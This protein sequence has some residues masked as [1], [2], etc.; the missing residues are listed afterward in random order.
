M[1]EITNALS[2]KNSSFCSKSRGFKFDTV[3]PYHP[4]AYDRKVVVKTAIVEILKNTTPGDRTQDVIGTY[5]D[6]R[7]DECGYTNAQ[8]RQMNFLFDLRRIM[9]YVTWETRTPEFVEGGQVT[10][11]SSSGDTKQLRVSPDLI[12]RGSD[13][14]GKPTAELVYIDPGKAYLTNKG[15][16][17]KAQRE[18]MMYATMLYARQLGFSGAT[19]SIYFMKK[20][21]D[22]N[23]QLDPDFY[24]RNVV[25]MKDLGDRTDDD[26]SDSV[27][28][29][30]NGED[31]SKMKEE[32][33]EHCKYHSICQYTLPPIKLIEENHSSNKMS[34][35]KPTDAQTQAMNAV[36]GIFRLNAGAGSGK[37]ATVTARTKHLIM[38]L[39]VRPE[40]ILMITFTDAGAKE[41]KA[42]IGALLEDAG[43]K[44]DIEA[45]NVVTFNSFGDTIVKEQYK[46][47]FAKPPIVINDVQR[48]A[49]IEKLLTAQPIPEW[50]G[51]P[52][53]N[54][55][56][57]LT[58]APGALL[59]AS[60]VFAAIRKLNI[61]AATVQDIHS[62]MESYQL[63]ETPDSVISKLIQL[64]DAYD[65]KLKANGLIEFI[66]QE[67]LMFEVLDSDPSYLM[68]HYG[69]RHIVV[70][71]F[72]DS[73]LG[74]IELIKRM[75]DM[76]TF[77]SLMVVGDDSQAIYGFRD[78]SPEY[79]INFQQYIGKP[80]QDIFLVDNYRSTPEIIDFANKI[81]AM[82]VDRVEKDLV[83][84]R[85]SN[86]IKPQVEGF[87]ALTSE[88]DYIVKGIKAHLDAG[89]APEDIAVI[90][91]T[92][93]ELQKIADLL[94]KAKIPSMIVAPEKA[95]KN[96]RIKAILAFS[97]VVS[98]TTDTKDALVCANAMVGG[99]IM[100][101]KQDKIQ[102]LVDQVL[103]RAR[104][105]SNAVT[106][107]AK[108]EAFMDFV[109]SIAMDDELVE[110]FKESVSNMEYDEMITYC[111]DFARYGETVEWKRL[112]RYPGVVLT[113]AH[114]SKGL[115][116][117][118][119]Y[120]SLSKYQKTAKV[121]EE[122]RRLLFVSATRARDELYITGQY[123]A[124][125]KGGDGRIMNKYLEN[126]F[127]ALGKQ[128]APQFVD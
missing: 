35:F 108:K 16:K 123:A 31:Y 45:L 7:Y 79:L 6:S 22:R 67:N 50:N 60:N 3:S 55:D 4:I 118:V 94:T 110:K 56:S 64:Y 102:S 28:A 51:K 53:L 105:I 8:Q 107:S 15:K 49:I 99:M 93:D 124:N 114:S 82:N 97:R 98:D 14:D 77:E 84:K 47:W 12:F 62:V 115:E 61:P 81:N 112:E 87:Y 40:E 96:S 70:D 19:V 57:Q 38:D 89:I 25:S 76:P 69:Y 80:T 101:L 75:T 88:Y 59:V 26:M 109:D 63:G 41:M 54:F 58:Y 52:F 91:Y 37:T 32:D 74:Q 86:G 122:T 13:S 126:S 18:V 48:L 103:V 11:T 78:T 34:A 44:G 30:V 20:E 23:G 90:T 111:F 128:Y 21:E 27:N 116:W 2:I 121:S 36:K 83:A 127:D 71:E 33:C 65:R 113:T 92:K 72:Q 43:W 85:P 42:R 119:V 104:E 106:L 68:N 17:D 5:L 24:G 120:N 100:D 117:P 39:G 29:W 46:R 95:M 1:A 9:R 66:D 10:L 73:S 125:K